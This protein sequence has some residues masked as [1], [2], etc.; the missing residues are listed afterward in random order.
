MPLL[1]ISL[2]YLLGLFL[3]SFLPWKGPG[4]LFIAGGCLVLWP[5][6]RWLPTARTAFITRL[7]WIARSEPHLYLPPI[8]LAGFLFFGVWRINASGPGLSHDHIAALNDRGSYRITAVVAAP[9]D[10]RD[11]STQLRL[12]VEK[13]APLDENGQAGEA[14][15]MHGQMMVLL[16]GRAEWQYGDRLEV[17]GYPLTP[18]E[19][20]DFS[21]RAYLA[22]QDIYT[23]LTYPRI[24][25]IGRGAGSPV[26]AAIYRLRDWA[27][28]E[29]MHLFPAPEA[30]LLAGILL[31]IESGMPDSLNRAFQ[32]T[33][34]AHII[35]ISGFNI[36]ILAGLF[37]T[38]FGRLFSR[39]WALIVSILAIGTYTMLVGATPSVVRAAIMGGLS[40]LAQQIGRRSAGL[41]TLFLTAGVMCLG[42]PQL[43]WDASFQLSFG[44]TAGLVLYGERF[45]QGFLRFLERR[46]SPDIA[47]RVAGP[48]GE[49][50]LLTLAAQVMTLPI[51]LYHFQRLSFSSLI[52]NPLVLP[53]QPLV[54]VV[55]GVAVLAGAISDPLAHMLAWLAWP[56]S[57]YT[58]R[59]VELLARIPGGVLVLDEFGP[60]TLALAYMAVLA[61]LAGTRYPR[62][63]RQ[64]VNPTLLL[65]SGGLLAAV[66]L[67]GAAAAPDGRLHLLVADLDG[68]QA[69]LVQAPGGETLLVNGG[70]STRL[71][72][73]ALG[74]RL[75]PFDRH[76]DALLMNNASAE[77][78][79][80]L[81]G[82]LE[83]YPPGLAL[84]GMD[85]PEG[86]AASDLGETLRVLQSPVRILS[87]GDSFTLGQEEIRLDTVLKGKQGSALLL[88][89]K[90]FRALIPGGSPPGQIPP[91][92]SANLSLLVLEQRD[93]EKTTPEEW[94]ALAPQAIIATPGSGPVLP[95]G[96]NWLNTQPRGW[97]QVVTNGEK[98]WV[99]QSR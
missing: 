92:A 80:A 44:A 88:R 47:R 69:L 4:W 39:W 72:I 14:R 41:N 23:Y 35:A 10:I 32:D 93:L 66:M 13:A 57:A 38:L 68:S 62:F 87:A 17:D 16:L 15:P 85:T 24:H 61:P 55:S 9:P 56:L 54:M 48:V 95:G 45:Q 63:M 49:Y 46:L 77:S 71:L 6:L 27:Y 89:W 33:G 42:N 98:M 11:R 74:R 97:Y 65:T 94:L 83:R 73:E 37:S 18:P 40:L 2:A 84:W 26:L 67:R 8:L 34:T 3:G 31:G 12:D 28:S 19:D 52:A 60:G 75:S 79:R 86:R 50:V 58:N 64:V 22:R 1:W 70:G 76:L 99:E 21:Y 90:N 7:G 30:P 96:M 78:I 43:P 36:A 53:P 81:P 20:E 82:V 25:R 51:I 91:G 59:M 29:V 5:L